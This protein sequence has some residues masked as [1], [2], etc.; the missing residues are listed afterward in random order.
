MR[1]PHLRKHG[2]SRKRCGEVIGSVHPVALGGPRLRWQAMPR[3]ST[4]REPAVPTT[5]PPQ[6]PGRNSW[7]DLLRLVDEIRRLAF[8][9]SLD[10]ADRSRRIRD[11]IREHDGEFD[12]P[13]DEQ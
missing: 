5:F 12:D 1:C 10:D 6:E 4:G 2:Q 3:A 7:A 11:A 8:D 9:R 13:E